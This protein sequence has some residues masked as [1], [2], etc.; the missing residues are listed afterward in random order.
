MEIF[1]NN[2]PICYNNACTVKKYCMSIIFLGGITM[3]N[4]KAY[5]GVIVSLLLVISI[6]V[7]LIIH[8]EKN[9]NDLLDVVDS[10][11]DLVEKQK[12][13]YEKMN[14]SWEESYDELQEKYGKAITDNTKLKDTNKKLK[15]KLNEVKVKEYSF[16]KEEIYLIAKCVEAEAGNYEN[17]KASQKYVCQV[18]L[19][20]LKSGKF[21]NTIKKVI[22]Q[23]NGNIPQFSVAYNGAMNRTVS[24]E[25]LANVYEVIV[26]GT[27]L[28]SYVLF[29]YSAS[30]EENWVNTLN[31]YTTVEGTVFAYSS[32]K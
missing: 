19:N 4:K 29:F 11:K 2:T 28:P 32:K 12:K 18:I 13:D 1:A 21:P 30:V 25:T 27:D 9:Y 20:R 3:L 7:G 5:K 10:Y 23:K 24:T 26:H 14:E 17:H 22:Y 16:T 8:L 31:T 6:L 15:E